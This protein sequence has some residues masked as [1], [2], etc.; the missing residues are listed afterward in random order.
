V[1]LLPVVVAIAVVVGP[2]CSEGTPHAG[3]S[4][5]G[6]G[7]TSSTTGSPSATPPPS[8]PAAGHTLPGTSA[9]P[10]SV[11]PSAPATTAPAAAGPAPTQ[12]W[13]NDVSVSASVSPRCVRPGGTVTMTVRTSSGAAI[14]YG[15][16]YADGEYGAAPP[17]GKGYGGSDHGLADGKGRYTTKWVVAPNA[18]RGA[19]VVDV[20]VGWHG[21]QG[22]AHPAFAVSGVDGSC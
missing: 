19:G 21:L 22:S 4:T 12:S 5:T 11:A 2:A 1:R 8:A 7:V 10:A 20:I 14:A 18:P 13:R 9:A 17:Y 6:T 16:K 15:A 3:P